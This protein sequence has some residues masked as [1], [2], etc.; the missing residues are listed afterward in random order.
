M[1]APSAPLQ[2]FIEDEL[3]RAPLLIDQVLQT[4]V[5]AP[6]RFDPTATS[7]QRFALM[8]TRENLERQR[9]I[10][11]RAFCDAL[12]EQVHRTAEQ[13]AAAARGLAL[14]QAD[15][16]SLSLVDDSEIEADVELSRAIEIIHS[17]A[18]YELRELRSFTSSLVG[19][20]YVAHETNPFRP[21]AY[22]RA[23]LA[24]VRALKAPPA[25]QLRLMHKAVTPFA[26]ALRKAYAAACS[27]LEDQG[28]QP[29][30]Y[31][32]VVLPPNAQG[33]RMRV[34]PP[35]DLNALR[36][37]MPVPFDM[38][39]VEPAGS[40]VPSARRGPGGP[41]TTGV[42]PVVVVVPGGMPGGSGTPVAI[43]AQTANPALLQPGAFPPLVM[44]PAAPSTAPAGSTPRAM[45]LAPP[46]P[47]AVPEARSRVDQQ[48]IELLTRLFDAILADRSLP[49]DVQLLLSRLQAPA[50]RVALRDPG[51]LDSYTHPVW[52]FLDRLVFSADR[53]PAEG[54]GRGQFLAYAKSLVENMSAESVQDAALYRWGIERLAAF[55]THLLE[56]HRRQA[57][58]Q[59]ESLR[60]LSVAPPGG[61]AT[62]VAPPAEAAL[63]VHSLE[64]VPAELMD[65]PDS[66]SGPQPTAPDPLPA[67][68]PGDWL[69]I[70]LQGSWR[71]LKLLWNDA[72]GEVWLF[73]QGGGRTWALRRAALER[74]NAAG[75]VDT[76]SPASLVQ[77]AA[78]QVMR[79]LPQAQPR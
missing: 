30:T 52:E 38:E 13:Q 53:L 50:V 36:D 68:Q 20:V 35:A 56:Q 76:M 46:L 63:D 67:M 18:E 58:L 49:G 29:G 28:V 47:G 72:R 17:T 21:D 33:Q 8:E 22:A 75:L 71:E 27:R 9:P 44:P 62:P 79:Q 3:A 61:G 78:Q 48:L 74:L 12:R 73:R 7:A 54:P 15:E 6:L 31:R 23:L 77:H 57:Q 64:T 16:L 60:G 45:P 66:F 69:R 37:S 65:L 2:R 1:P 25:D 19:D 51:V 39:P 14:A 55:D 24:C 43:P 70:F 41:T 26:Q 42:P 34:L 11:V 10:L 32:T 5:G 40:Q 4:L 59:I